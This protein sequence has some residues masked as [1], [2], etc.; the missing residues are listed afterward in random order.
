MGLAELFLELGDPSFERFKP[1]PQR[2]QLAVQ[3]RPFVLF[4]FR[5]DASLVS[6]ARQP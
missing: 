4:L 1:F 2:D 6:R 5:H 3:H